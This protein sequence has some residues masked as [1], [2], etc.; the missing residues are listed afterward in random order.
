MSN[1]DKRVIDWI[2][3]RLAWVTRT[4]SVSAERVA[5]QTV[6]DGFVNRLASYTYALGI[7]LRGVQTGSLRQYI[8]FIGAGT[9][10]VFAVASF[11]WGAG[12]GR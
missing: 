5:D 12:F 1:F 11:F 7:K 2:L 9:V 10:A 8:M 6:V 3:D 4:F